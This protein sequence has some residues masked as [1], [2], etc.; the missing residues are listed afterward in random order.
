MKHKIGILGFP[1]GLLQSEFIFLLSQ[2]TATSR[3]GIKSIQTLLLPII[4][5]NGNYTV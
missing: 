5:K 2:I 1:A 4:L 3:A